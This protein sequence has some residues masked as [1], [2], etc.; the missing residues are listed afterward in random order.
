[1]FLLLTVLTCLCLVLLTCREQLALLP[2]E[3]GL[4]HCRLMLK[5]FMALKFSV[6][7]SDLTAF[8]IR[9]MTA[10]LLNAWAPLGVL[11]SVV[12]AKTPVTV[13]AL[14]LWVDRMSSD[15]VFLYVVM[16]LLQS[17]KSS[18][19]TFG[20]TNRRMVHVALSVRFTP[21]SRFVI[22]L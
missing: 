22:V 1:M 3:T 13:L 2:L 7:S 4:L 8:D 17:S 5:W 6:A 20:L 14:R 12:I 11:I 18:T 15:V 10:E 16:V 19:A 21:G 9:S